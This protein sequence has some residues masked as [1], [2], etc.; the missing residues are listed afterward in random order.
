MLSN[1]AIPHR[2]GKATP[3]R[4]DES[5]CNKTATQV[6]SRKS[7]Q[8]TETDG[9]SVERAIRYHGHIGLSGHK[10]EL[11]RL[12][13]RAPVTQGVGAS[14]EWERG[15]VNAASPYMTNSNRPFF[16]HL[17]S[18]IGLPYPPG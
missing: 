15:G 18:P 2:C 4:R 7:L 9:R 5:A 11:L 13:R 3:Q 14:V 6:R 17:H 16:L 12:S 1:P 10:R 8:K